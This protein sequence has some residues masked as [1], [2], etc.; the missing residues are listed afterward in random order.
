MIRLLV[1]CLFSLCTVAASAATYTSAS[2]PFSWINSA[3][4]T[5]VGHNTLPYKFTNATGCGTAPPTLDDTLSEV[6]PIGFTFLYGTVSYTT[7]RIMTNGRLQFNNTTCGAGT[8]NIGPPQTYPYL[9]PVA[10]MNN[11]M[12]VFGV[13]LDPT[14]LVDKPNYPTVANKT[15]CINSASCY[16]SYA[17]IGTA[18]NRQFVVTWWHVPE[19]VSNNNTSGSFDLQVILNENG[20]FIYQY[21]AVTHGG[22]GQA[23]IGWQLSTTDYEVLTFGAAAEPS[24]NTAIVFYIPSAGPFAEYRFD[25]GA[26]SPN[27][28]GQVTDSSGNNRP[29]MALGSAQETASGYVCRGAAIPV[30]TTASPA[31]AVQTGINLSNASL[32][33]LGQGTIMFW[34]KANAAWNSG[35]AA[36]L[37]DATEVDGQWFY[38]TKTGTGTLYFQVMDS[39]GT[40]RS[41]ETVA[42]TIAA[43]TWVHVTV[44]WNFNASPSANQDRLSILINAGT[45]KT[46]SF[47]SSGTVTPSAGW[48][49]AGDNAAGFVGTKGTV[50]SANGTLDELRFYNFEMNQGQ[51]AGARSQTHVCPA[52]GTI[53]HFELRHASWIGSACTPGTL[54]VVACANAA[55]SSF[56]TSGVIATLSSSGAATVWDAAT[57]GSTVIVGNTQSSTTKDFYTGAGTATFD[58]VGTGFPV[59]ALNAK[60]CNGISG[61]CN[62]TSTNGGLIVTVPNSGV[63][64]GGEPTAVAVQAVESTAPTPAAPCV[65]VKGLSGAGL[66]VWTT[67]DTPASFPATSTSAGATVGGAPQL[68]NAQAGSYVYTPQ[69][70]P[71]ADNVSSLTFDTN[72]SANVWFKHMDTGRWNL[73]ARLDKA[74]SA[75]APLLSLDGNTV[76]TMVPVGYGVAASA[77][78][79]SAATQA[80][81][82]SG[83]VAA[84][85]TAAVADTKVGIAGADFNVT[86]TAALW[87]A[88]GDVDLSNNPVAPSYAGSVAL[89]P[90]LV[91]PMG[92]A[93]GAL[94]VTSLTLANGQATSSSEKWSEVGAVRIFGSGTYLG[95]S[96]NPS[97]VGQKTILNPVLGRFVPHHFD[98]VVSSV[99]SAAFTYSGQLFPLKVTASNLAGVT[100]ANYQG[101]FAKAGTYSDANGAVGSFTPATLD[102][103]KFAAGV[104]DL[105]AAPEVKFDFSSKLT[106]PWTLILRVVDSDSV[107]SAVLPGVEGTMLLRSGRLWLGNAYGSDQL[108]LTVPVETQYWN[109]S[110]FVKNTLDSCTALAAGNIALGNKLG[111]LSAYTGPI[112]VSAIAGGAGTIG[113]AKP[114]AA[115]A[116]SVDVMATLGS[117]GSPSNCN[118]VTGA[119]SAALTHLS[120]KWC[121]A[122]YDRDPVARATFGIAGSSSK[123]GPIYIRESY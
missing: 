33:L 82:A 65:P 51:V 107:S 60:K 13:D 69:T 120:G 110:A 122:S 98:T 54:T 4:H 64:T 80:A 19:W 37:V 22:T 66:K 116:G 84:C 111:G 70:M 100:T 93:V 91:A 45:P 30:N 18:P 72:A 53:D 40:S 85:D 114:A 106:A 56:Y 89:S 86:V 109:G 15:N 32:N 44:S 94:G 47:T 102:S 39:S 75:T 99:C 57:G 38:L 23:Q 73:Y 58:I 12:K 118:S 78:N 43:G 103:S 46:S 90:A 7:L 52:L 16:I 88:S 42:Q 55:C 49:R 29:G 62:W 9:Y 96:I 5:K 3:T 26:W 21:G 83:P 34:Y 112:T 117:V 123:K 35:V 79:A 25:D 71:V 77:L 1:F 97:G 2:T 68:S 113:L 95:K 24:P 8:Q 67:A 28:A 17:S 36:Q 50:N 92:G 20:T 63:I 10:S 105:M 108:A 11:T 76:V 87:T 14:N 27:G 31:D 101:A 6:I 41:V 74:A 119:T 48:V 59:S 61:S 115:T 81:C 104:A 121:G